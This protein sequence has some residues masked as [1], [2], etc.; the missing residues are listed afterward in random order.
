MNGI[1][2][3]P[4]D[5]IADVRRGLRGALGNAAAAIVEATELPAAE[6]DV[7]L[8]T[9]HRA[10][11]GG[12]CVLLDVVGWADQRE[13]V[14]AHVDLRAHRRAFGE[15][16]ELALL[17][18]EDELEEVGVLADREAQNGHGH[19]RASAIGALRE[20]SRRIADLAARLD[21]EEARRGT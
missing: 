1:V 8:Y 15:A 5:L 11:L 12:A 2:T 17:V 21:R 19:R 4:P 3:V 6:Q 16:L 18:A 10:Q 20:Y 14:A 7:E 13:E 9:E